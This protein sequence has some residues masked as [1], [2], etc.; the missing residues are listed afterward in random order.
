MNANVC[1]IVLPKRAQARAL[2]AYIGA[3]E[4]DIYLVRVSGDYKLA[5]REVRQK[6][7]KRAFTRNLVLSIL[8]RKYD[9]YA[10]NYRPVADAKTAMMFDNDHP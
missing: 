7:Y 8:I 2:A 9:F 5:D 10:A 1:D 4:D 6:E 3:L